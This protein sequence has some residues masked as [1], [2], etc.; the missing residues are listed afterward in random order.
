MSQVEID[1]ACA[2]FAGGFVNEGTEVVVVVREGED[3]NDVSTT[4]TTAQA[5]PASPSEAVVAIAQA[6]GVALR[7]V[8]ATVY[9]LVGGV[10]GDKV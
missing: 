1:S 4:V 2:S 3:A 8:R 6:C 5:A 10:D 9:V 7:D